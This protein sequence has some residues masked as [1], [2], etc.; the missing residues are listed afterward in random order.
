[1]TIAGDIL[2]LAALAY[3]ALRELQRRARGPH[4]SGSSG[5]SLHGSR[6]RGG[7]KR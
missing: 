2:I 5:S 7:G 6:S 3:V 1:M 4:G